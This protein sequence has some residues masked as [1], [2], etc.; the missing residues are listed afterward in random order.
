V[1][2]HVFIALVIVGLSFVVSV[3]AVIED[4]WDRPLVSDEQVMW[5]L[6]T[7]FAPPYGGL[8]YWWQRCRSTL[9]APV[10]SI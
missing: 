10:Q 2:P 7:S 6:L 1:P 8:A 5:I 4:I 3:V 9:P